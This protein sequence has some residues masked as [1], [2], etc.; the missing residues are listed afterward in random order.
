[1]HTTS[2]DELLLH[3]HIFTRNTSPDELLLDERQVVQLGQQPRQVVRHQARLVVGGSAER[4]HRRPP[5][6]PVRILNQVQKVGD[7]LL[8]VRVDRLRPLNNGEL[9]GGHDGGAGEGRSASGVLLQLRK[10]LWVSC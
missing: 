3:E 1:L 10:E 6:V 2:P 4:G 5:D 8:D 9:E 7:R